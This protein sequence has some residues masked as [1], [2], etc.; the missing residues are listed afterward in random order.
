MRLL[1]KW[2][3]VSRRRQACTKMPNRPRKGRVKQSW[4]YSQ[5]E[6]IKEEE[7]EEVWQKENQMELQWAEDEK[8]EES[9]ER[10]R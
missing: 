3:P 2:L 6:K 5:I 9:L 8:L 7:E 10:R 4:D 1:K